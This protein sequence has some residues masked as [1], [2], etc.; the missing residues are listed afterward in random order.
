M[1]NYELMTIVDAVLSEDK[2]KAL[3]KEIQ[4]F[5]E[6]MDGKVTKTDFWGKRKLAYEIGSTKEGYYDVIYFELLPENLEKLKVKLK[7]MENVT[8]YLVT[9]KS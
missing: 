2:A 8:R 6:T 7:L 4:T 1:S 3:S 9:A 5:I